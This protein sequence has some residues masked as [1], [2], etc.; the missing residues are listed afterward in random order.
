MVEIFLA[1]KKRAKST[2][3]ALQK[4]LGLLEGVKFLAQS[5]VYVDLE[6]EEEK[7][8]PKHVSCAWTLHEGKGKYSQE[9]KEEKGSMLWKK[10]TVIFFPAPSS[11][12]PPLLS[13]LQPAGLRRRRR[14]RR[15]HA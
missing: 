13:W 1:F 2:E 11:L 10:K 9:E 6:E 4:N 14:R 8:A 5:H 7:E 12:P 3:A 15:H